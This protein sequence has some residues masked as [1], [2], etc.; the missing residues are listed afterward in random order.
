MN[1]LSFLSRKAAKSSF[2]FYHFYRFTFITFRTSNE[3]QQVHISLHRSQVLE[4]MF[5]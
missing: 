2:A 4:I 5:V 3:Q 1:N